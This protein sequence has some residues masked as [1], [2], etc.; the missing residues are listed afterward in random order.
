MGQKQTQQDPVDLVRFGVE[1][2]NRPVR[3][4]ANQIANQL[5]ITKRYGTS[6]DEMIVVKMP[7]QAARLATERHRAARES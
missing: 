7:S 4:F 5:R 3:S 2:G 6:Q 1:S